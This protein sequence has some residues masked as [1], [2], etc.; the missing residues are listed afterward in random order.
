MMRFSGKLRILNKY[1]NPA[2]K[3][4]LARHVIDPAA[5]TADLRQ[6][7]LWLR[8]LKDLDPETHREAEGELSRLVSELDRPFAKAARSGDRDAA[9]AV[10]YFVTEALRF[11]APA[12]D[13][14][15]RVK[16]FVDRVKSYGFQIAGE[17]VICIR[18]AAFANLAFI[19]GSMT[20]VMNP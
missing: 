5:L 12:V 16:L 11:S 4:S 7:T 8:S 6:L 10:G 17:P 13:S 19:A 1:G 15:D 20:V 3:I 18:N 9:R 14:P 2:T